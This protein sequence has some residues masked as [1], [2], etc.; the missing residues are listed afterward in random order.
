M[1]TR[2]PA[3]PVPA[4]DRTK[5]ERVT[6]FRLC[7]RCG[8]TLDPATAGQRGPCR[9]CE[10][11]RSGQR[12]AA[13]EPGVLIRSTAKWQRTRATALRRD[14]HSCTSCGA[15]GQR[16]E[17]HHVQPIAAG[18]AAYDLRNLVTLCPSCHHKL[19]GRTP[20][21][22]RPIPHPRPGF[23]GTQARFQICIGTTE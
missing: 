1:S 17:V 4:T 3:A 10:R 6:I 8:A 21:F 20:F 23:R 9:K 2:T 22:E 13:G 19:E 7:P 14:R 12:R 18:G 5:G 11:D 15:S 16:L